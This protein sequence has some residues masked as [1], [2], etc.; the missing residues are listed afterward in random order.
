MALTKTDYILNSIRKVRNKKWEFFIITRIIHALPD[1]IEFKT[2]QLVRLS[3]DTRALTDLYFPQFDI[4]LEIDEPF[5]EKQVDADK[6]R[7][8]DII[9]RTEHSVMRIKLEA[10]KDLNSVCIEVDKFISKILAIKDKQIADGSFNPWDFDNK[11]SSEPIIK[12]GQIS[13]AKNIVFQKQIE[14]LRCFGFAG[15]G[16]QRGAWVIPDGSDDYVWFPRL[17][18]HGIWENKLSLDGKTIT[19]RALDNKEEAILSIAKQKQVELTKGNRKTIVFAKVKD[20]LGF[21]LY[22]YV[23]TFRMNLDKSTDTEIIF[24]RVSTEEKVRL[25]KTMNTADTETEYDPSGKWGTGAPK[26]ISD[27]L[28]KLISSGKLEIKN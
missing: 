12:S 17:Y 19:E 15:Q 27:K 20:S 21:N 25:P 2:Q 26:D 8:M 10:C 9:A 14:A 16:Y 22:R 23:G 24:D 1:D 28:G 13:I 6:L 3:N 4:H 18:K 11:Y 7:E 5:H